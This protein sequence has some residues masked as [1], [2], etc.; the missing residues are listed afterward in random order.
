LMQTCLQTTTVQCPKKEFKFAV[1]KQ[2]VKYALW[3]AKEAH[4]YFLKGCSRNRKVSDFFERVESKLNNVTS[5]NNKLPQLLSVLNSHTG[6]KVIEFPT[7][8]DFE[9]KIVKLSKT[10]EISPHKIVFDQLSDR[11]F[12]SS[13]KKQIKASPKYLEA[14][15]R[16]YLTRILDADVLIRMI[17][18]MLVEDIVENGQKTLRIKKPYTKNLW[19]NWGHILKNRHKDTLEGY[20]DKIIAFQKKILAFRKKHSRSDKPAAEQ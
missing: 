3:K 14:V 8:L 11:F 1:D 10:V 20:T 18:D 7:E 2:V 5:G 6:L 4:G 17:E 19:N 15:Q 16:E 9:E 12:A 13:Y